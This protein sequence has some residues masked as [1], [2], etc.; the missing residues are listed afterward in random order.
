MLGFSES[1]KPIDSTRPIRLNM[2]RQGR[3]SSHRDRSHTYNRLEP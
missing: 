2:V 3:Q 1:A